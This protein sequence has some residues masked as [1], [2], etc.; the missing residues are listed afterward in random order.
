MP[1]PVPEH[2]LEQA[3]R[4]VKDQRSTD[5]RRAL[6]NAYYA[7]FHFVLT[8]AADMVV[9][10]EQRTSDSYNLVYQ[11]VEHAR[12]RDFCEEVNKTKP[13]KVAFTPLGGFGSIAEFA[14][15]TLNLYELGIRADYDPSIAFS[16]SGAIIAVSSARQAISLFEEASAER[17]Q[18][19][20]TMLLFKE[21]PR[22]VVAIDPRFIE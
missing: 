20:L 16:V 10:A 18:A 19:F 8:A 15:I 12:L 22:K 2:L 5:L 7:V 3:D 13:Q 21:R 1:P 14:G 6:S 9:G 4:L 17:R 11:S